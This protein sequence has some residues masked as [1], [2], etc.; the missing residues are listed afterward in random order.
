M[1]LEDDIREILE[2]VRWLEDTVRAMGFGGPRV[3]P[4]DGKETKPDPKAKP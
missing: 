4:G 1:S 2:T 3:R